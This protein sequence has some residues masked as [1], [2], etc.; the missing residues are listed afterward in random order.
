MIRVRKPNTGKD[1]IFLE[2]LTVL[3]RSHDVGLTVY[4][5]SID[6]QLLAPSRPWA[7]VWF[8]TILE[9]CKWP[10]TRAFI[11]AHFDI[12]NINGSLDADLDPIGTLVAIKNLGLTLENARNPDCQE[13]EKNINHAVQQIEHCL[14]EIYLA[15]ETKHKEL[16]ALAH[17][18]SNIVLS[19]G[20]EEIEGVLLLLDGKPNV[21]LEDASP[22]KTAAGNPYNIIMDVTSNQ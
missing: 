3:L 8:K 19:P 16:K 22:R 9:I 1:S 7:L 18:H 17:Q 14:R 20:Y 12:D 13:T 10:E 2:V 5:Q 6:D 4:D 15:Y 11:D 21:K